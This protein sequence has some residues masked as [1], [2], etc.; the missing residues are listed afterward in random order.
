MRMPV[1]D[2][3]AGPGTPPPAPAP[4]PTPIYKPPLPPDNEQE[5]LG[6]S[7]GTPSVPVPPP[8]EA[9][10][11]GGGGNSGGGSSDG[12][13]GGDTGT[14]APALDWRA[15]LENWGFPPDVISQLDRIFRGDSDPVRAAAT[16]LA[17]IR[18]TSWYAQTFPG[19]SEGIR[20]GLIRDERDYRAFMNQA[21]QLYRRYQNRDISAAELGGH[22]TEGVDLDTIGKRFEGDAYIGAF[23]NDI[24]YLN[25]NFGGAGLSQEELTAYGRQQVGLGSTLGAT[26]ARRVQTAE[27]RLRR[28]FEGTLASPTLQHGRQGLQATSLGAGPPDIGR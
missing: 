8:R 19:I 18:G 21:N 22:F 20:K 13:A 4:V 6:P 11:G 25:R 27:Q 24:Q 1:L 23:G 10:G 5:H 14:P 28:L 12:G 2:P 17:Y 7:P 3:G 26:L 9:P 16:A 15:W